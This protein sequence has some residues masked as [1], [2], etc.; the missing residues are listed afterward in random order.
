M[1]FKNIVPW[2]RQR[3]HLKISTTLCVIATL[4]P[5]YVR[6][7]TKKVLD[8]GKASLVYNSVKLSSV[9]KSFEKF[10]KFPFANLGHLSVTTNLAVHYYNIQLLYSQHV[11]SSLIAQCCTKN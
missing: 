6:T 4:R 11:D 8:F 9:S 1:P 10:P 5:E 7:T 3:G 2:K